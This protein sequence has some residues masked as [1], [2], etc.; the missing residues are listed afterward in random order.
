MRT[1]IV[2]LLLVSSVAFADSP[3]GELETKSKDFADI[4]ETQENHKSLSLNV[5]RVK[6]QL[7]AGIQVPGVTN[8]TVS[9]EIELHFAKN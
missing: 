7:D 1:I 5:I 9:P 3:A 6:A 8:A 2:C 4:L